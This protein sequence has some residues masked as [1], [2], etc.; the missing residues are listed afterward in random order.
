MPALGVPEFMVLLFM[1]LV[2]GVSF[3]VIWKFYRILSRMNDN[4]SGI[5]EAIDRHG[6][7]PSAD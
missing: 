2:Y 7:R 5:R 1:F 6:N 4:L 3:F